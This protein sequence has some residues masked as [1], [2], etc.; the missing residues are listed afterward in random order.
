M[1][2]RRASPLDKKTPKRPRDSLRRLFRHVVA[3]GYSVPAAVR[4][5]GPP[6]VE[7]ISIE[8]WQIIALGPQAEQ[9]TLQGS[10][11]LAVGFVVKAIERWPGAIVL[12]HP[13]DRIGILNGRE[14]VR[15][16]LRAHRHIAS[17]KAV[18]EPRS[19]PA[20]WKRSKPSRAIN[21]RQSC[22]FARFD[23]PA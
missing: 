4:R 15:V 7:H 6:D 3:A 2:S 1:L 22:A 12:Q 18:Y 19:W 5:P 14:K 17:R 8:F 9:G 23:E 20:T 21:S 16:V 10:P 13:T 11:V